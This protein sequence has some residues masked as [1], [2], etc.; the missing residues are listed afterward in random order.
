MTKRTRVLFAL[1]AALLAI[2]MLFSVFYIAAE[3]GHD[4]AGE[5]CRICRQIAICRDTLRLI[6]LAVA[7]A[8]LVSLSSGAYRG[9]AFR[10]ASAASQFTLVSL[11]VKLSD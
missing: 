2:V 1:T 10:C 9:T 8:V 5:D 6:T 4:C 7:A 11:K 3:T